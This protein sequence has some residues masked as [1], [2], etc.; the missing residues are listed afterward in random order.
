MMN[1][2]QSPRLR[3]WRY[4]LLLPVLALATGLLSATTG[5]V[6]MDSGADKYLVTE[7]GVIHGMVT[8]LSTDQDLADMKAA[9]A[10]KDIHLSIPV[11][12]RN[13]AG[14]I[15][16]IQ[17]EA[18]D[19]RSSV[20]E[21]LDEGPISPFFFYFGK[22]E[23]GIGEMPFKH[24]PQSLLNRAIAESNG[25]TKGI[26]TD[27]TFLNRFAG[28]KEGYAKFLARNIRYPRHCQEN[29][30][31]G[32]VTAQYQILPSGEVTNAEVLL[33]PDKVMGDE[34]V[35]IIK[36]LPAFKADATGKT[37]TASLNITFQLEVAG[38]T[39]KGP[40]TDRDGTVM[41]IGYGKQ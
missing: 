31:V 12:K 6:V 16:N 10:V 18:K 37:V 33:S 22:T 7:N 3:T 8:R 4:L 20:T 39:L 17:F 38:K 11:L 27:S 5:N 21:T 24:T 14:E 34:V 15:I 40:D 23:S 1:K 28:G 13:A 41:V 36:M 2:T 19:K 30:I 25:K 9:L 35:R 26:T 29:N 32:N